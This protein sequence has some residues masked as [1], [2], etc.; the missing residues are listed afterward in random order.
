LKVG[1]RHDL[2]TT[3]ITREVTDGCRQQ[4]ESVSLDTVG[5]ALIIH[6]VGAGLSVHLKF[7]SP[8]IRLKPQPTQA[9]LFNVG[10]EETESADKSIHD[11]HIDD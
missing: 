8:A 11:G 3:S 1:L 6:R 7:Q 9:A 4:L 5:T 2:V 10:V